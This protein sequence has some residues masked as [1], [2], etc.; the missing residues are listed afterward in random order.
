MISNKILSILQKSKQRINEYFLMKKSLTK[1][2]NSLKNLYVL[3]IGFDE[4]HSGKKNPKRF[5]LCILFCFLMYLATIY[6]LIMLTSEQFWSSISGPHLPDYARTCYFL[7]FIVFSLVCV[8]KTDAILAQVNYNNISP[9]KIFY[10]LVN[11]IKPKHKLTDKNYK[12]LAI[13]IRFILICLV[14]YGLPILSILLIGVETMITVKSKKLFWLIQELIITPFYIDLIITITVATSV[15]IIFYLYY[16][17]RFDQ[18]ND[19]FKLISSKLL[20]STIIPKRRELQLIRLIYKH[21]QMSIEIHIFNMILRRIAA[22]IFLS[23]SLVLIITIYLAIHMKDNLLRIFIINMF[24]CFFI[25][26]FVLTY[27]FALQIESAHQSYQLIHS[28]ICKFKMRYIIRIK[29]WISINKIK[30]HFLLFFKLI[31]FVQRLS[32][33]PI[34]LYCYNI[35]PF[36]TNTFC[37]VI[38]QIKL[39]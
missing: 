3:P 37:K 17:F 27:V 1:L 29:V 39:N 8:I 9:M 24:L 5:K 15:V 31:N 16:K 19:Q 10:Y 4:I 32:G 34:G 18:I 22:M 6:D 12:I 11:D 36:D 30:V 26:G 38:N 23:L 20:T 14:D 35:A 25:F 28:L 2:S 13:S 33:P 7:L 21:N